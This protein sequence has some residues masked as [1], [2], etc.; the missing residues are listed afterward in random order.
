MTATPIPRTLAL[1]IYGDLDVS[2]IDELPKGRVPIQTKVLNS[3]YEQK[4][5]DF[6]AKELEKGNQAFVVCPLIEESETLDMENTQKIYEKLKNDV[7]SNRKVGLLHG[8]MKPSEK[9]DV[10]K[11]LQ[12]KEISILVSTTVVEVGV[13]LPNA[14]VMMIL[15]AERFG[16]A[17]L[18]QLRGRVGRGLKESYCFLVLGDEKSRKR[19]EILEKSTDGFKISEF[20]LK[21]RG[22]GEFFGTRQHGLPSLRLSNLTYSMDT[23]NLA[24][25][26]ANDLL[27]EDADLKLEKNG[28]IKQ[29]VNLLFSKRS[30]INQM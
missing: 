27:I 6:I 1:I 22:P 3:K 12:S 29:Q 19:L 25:E 24:K 8:K 17:T 16:L 9:E 7:F 28:T 5:Y 13:D 21:N 30:Y 20:D 15:N 26:A 2:I 11:K 10:M 4:A 23:V 18:H 14:T